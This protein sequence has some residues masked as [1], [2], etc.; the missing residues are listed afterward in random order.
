MPIF[1]QSAT[2]TVFQADPLDVQ[3]KYASDI[4][5]KL[6]KSDLKTVLRY[7]EQLGILIDHFFTSAKFYHFVILGY[8]VN[9]YTTH[10][11]DASK[12]IF[13]IEGPQYTRYVDNRIE[14]FIRSLKVSLAYRYDKFPGDHLK[15]NIIYRN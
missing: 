7:N 2:L 3:L 4:F 14:A 1:R 11:D 15:M 10:N 5:S 6:I 12:L 8:V 13:L 9:L